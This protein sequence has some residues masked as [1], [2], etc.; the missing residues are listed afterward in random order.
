MHISH[1]FRNTKG[2]TC[3]TVLAAGLSAFFSNSTYA[4]S[5]AE[6]LQKMTDSGMLTHQE[7]VDTAKL[8]SA[9]S[10]PIKTTTTAK[11]NISGGL[12]VQYAYLNTEATSGPDDGRYKTTQGFMLRRV[13]A[14][15][16]SDLGAGWGTQISLDY[17]LP[18][19]MSNTFF[20]KKIDTNYFTG[21]IRA[22]YFKP[23][24]CLE[25]Y[26]SAFNQ[27]CIE[28]SLATNYWTGATG[29]DTK[30]GRTSKTKIGFGGMITGCWWYGKSQT[31][32]GLDY[33]FGASN[34]DNY[35]L[36]FFDM[37]RGGAENSPDFWA[38]VQYNKKLDCG[39]IKLGLNLA[40]GDDANKIK[41]NKAEAIWGANPF[42]E[43]EGSHL[44]TTFEF[45]IA[46]IDDG[47]KMRD[48]SYDYALPYGLNYS[49]EYKIPTAVGQIAPIFRYAFLETDGRG[50]S[51][52]DALR[53]AANLDSADIYKSAQSFYFGI[54]WYIKGNDLKLQIGYEFAQFRGSPSAGKGVHEGNVL[55]ANTIRTEMQIRF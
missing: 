14:T 24:F 51:A 17:I 35:Q 23:N 47:R 41:D 54:N 18:H 31:I 3:L 8:M 10:A 43:F 44:K 20:Y 16:K 12:Q 55:D 4:Q 46:G 13:I 28:R 50:V 1:P 21:Q 52:S 9:V 34:S 15:F 39:K 27:Y 29:A 45:L 6:M 11:V 30:R 7:A 19:H 33:A 25:E 38:S 22:G 40:Y 48:G 42:V 32:K 5:D 26:T 37:H 53:K 2:T 36:E 49:I